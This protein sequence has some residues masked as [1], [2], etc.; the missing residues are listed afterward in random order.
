MASVKTYEDQNVVLQYHPNEKIVNLEL[1]PGGNKDGLKSLE[2]KI[3]TTLSVDST[4][5]ET[6]NSSIL[7]LD[8]QSVDDMVHEFLQTILDG[9]QE[10]EDA[11]E[12]GQDASTEDA[13]QPPPPPPAPEVAP[14]APQPGQEEVPTESFG[15]FD[16]FEMLFE[17]T[18]RTGEY[19]DDLQ[20]AL[21]KGRQ[22]IQTSDII[23]ARRLYTKK[24]KSA[25]RD[26]VLRALDKASKY[27]VRLLRRQG[28]VQEAEKFKMRY[29]KIGQLTPL[30][31]ADK[32][33]G[34]EEPEEQGFDPRS[35]DFSDFFPSNE[36][37]EEDDEIEI[38]A[39]G[40]EEY[41]E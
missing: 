1:K 32:S 29:R 27:F 22:H 36:E 2:D 5:K 41:P 26:K 7:Q 17:S 21:G 24:K 9:G 11:Q 39:P 8:K 10:S 38:P 6:P 40:E 25:G 35:V 14:Q 18:Y 23:S 28:S 30:D 31:Y 16:A 37:E 3:K 19:W 4:T 20:Q 34:S 33:A 12:V 15:A 13:Q